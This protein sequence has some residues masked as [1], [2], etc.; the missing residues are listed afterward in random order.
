MASLF[1]FFTLIH[2][3]ET[4]FHIQIL[5][6]NRR[7]VLPQFMTWMDQVGANAFY[8]CFRVQARFTTTKSC[9]LPKLTKHRSKNFI[10]SHQRGSHKLSYHN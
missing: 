7:A 5:S 6:K 1:S 2:L 9:R 4:S 3:N 10:G 8:F